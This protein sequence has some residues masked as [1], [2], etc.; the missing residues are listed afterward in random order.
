MKKISFVAV[1]VALAVA[2][3]LPLAGFAQG[4][5]KTAST[6]AN[7][8]SGLMSYLPPSDA[9]ALINVNRL[10]DEAMPKLLA[11][12]PARLAEVS[13]ELANFKTQTGL[14]PR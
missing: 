14:D 11:E 10:L 5:R 13:N 6:P 1:I 12:N 2:L 9:V 8:T 7:P 3:V 4:S